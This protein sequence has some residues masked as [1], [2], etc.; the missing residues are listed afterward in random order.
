MWFIV[1]VDIFIRNRFY[2][3]F[4]ERVFLNIFNTQ[5]GITISTPLEKLLQMY[6]LRKGDENHT[7]GILVVASFVNI[8]TAYIDCLISFH[9]T[10]ATWTRTKEQQF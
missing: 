8:F 4:I 10:F 2:L 9:V 5:Y 7:H 3:G 6:N 1:Y